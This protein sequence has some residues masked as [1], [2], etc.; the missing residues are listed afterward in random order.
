MTGSEEELVPATMARS[1]PMTRSE[2]PVTTGAPVTT[3]TG[4][5]PK[6]MMI[7][8]FYTP[9]GPHYYDGVLYQQSRLYHNPHPSQHCSGATSIRIP[10]KRQQHGHHLEEDEDKDDD[11]GTQ[12]EALE[13]DRQWMQWDIKEVVLTIP[14]LVI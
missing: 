7:P 9:L 5:V 14:N 11:L 10:P 4:T 3:D 6:T 2:V 13:R 12:L 1:T 8:V